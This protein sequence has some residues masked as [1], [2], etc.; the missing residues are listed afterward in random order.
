MLSYSFARKTAVVTGGASGIGRAIALRFAAAG[1]NVVIADIAEAGGRET[2]GMIE[3]RGGVASYVK[4]DV[5][6]AKEVENLMGTAAELYGRVDYACN[7]AAVDLE[8]T[9][10]ADCKDEIFDR[11]IAVNLRGTYLCMKH[12]VR[13]MRKQRGPGAIV[14]FSSVAAFRSKALYLNAYVASKQ[15]VLAL[16]RI[17]AMQYAKEGIRINTIV[18][19]AIDTPLLRTTLAFRNLTLEDLGASYGLMGRVGT[20]EEIAEA[21]AWLCSE[22]SSFTVGAILPV[23]GGALIG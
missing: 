20:P 14:N 15:G 11:V 10:L 7:V 8:T 17:A 4:T 5:S 12:E 2:T 19:G 23:D 9:P 13:Q 3:S 18:P 21:A 16:T 1:A 6:E 22:Y